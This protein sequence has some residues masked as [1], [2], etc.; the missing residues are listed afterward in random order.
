MVH[1]Q[2]LEMQL[3]AIGLP[4]GDFKADNQELSVKIYCWHQAKKTLQII[5]KIVSS[6][7]K[8]G[9]DFCQEAPIYSVGKTCCC[10][11]REA[12]CHIS[13]PACVYTSHIQN[14]RE[15]QEWVE[16]AVYSEQ[17]CLQIPKMR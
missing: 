5:L 14:R 4:L 3:N 11:W 1:Q 6:C 8:K 10:L 16:N 2:P 9:R 7:T 13:K 12:G 17:S 15:E